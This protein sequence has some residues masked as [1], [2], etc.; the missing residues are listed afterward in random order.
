VHPHIVTFIGSHEDVRQPG[1]PS[2]CLLMAPAGEGNLEELFT[3]LGDHS[4]SSEFSIGWKSCLRSWVVCLP[5]AL[6]YM[7]AC[8][9]RHRDVKP[10]NIVYKGEQ[11][12]FT[13]FSLSAE[14]EVGHTTS[15]D[16]PARSTPMYCAQEEISGMTKHSTTTD[17]FFLGCVLSDM[18]AAVESH[19]V[20]DFRDYLRHDGSAADNAGWG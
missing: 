19:R 16:N 2:Y 4:P 1:R 3:I 17:I 15:A 8:G 6:E 18:L 20:S 13:D 14:F 5:T 10:S 11:V 7:H 9:T 12:F